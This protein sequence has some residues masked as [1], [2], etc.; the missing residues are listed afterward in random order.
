MKITIYVKLNDTTYQTGRKGPK[1]NLGE[2]IYS[3]NKMNLLENKS[4]K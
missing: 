4:T 3:S 1:G 2:Y